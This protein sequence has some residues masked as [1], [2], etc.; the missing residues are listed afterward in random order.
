MHWT[1]TKPTETGWYWWRN[2][3]YEG[4]HHV[5]MTISGPCVTTCEEEIEEM[6]GEWSSCPVPKP[7]EAP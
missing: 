2:P 7:E 6:G 5:E 4:I 1:T 3:P